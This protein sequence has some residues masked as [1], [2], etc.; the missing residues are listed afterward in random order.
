M[1]TGPSASKKDTSRCQSVTYFAANPSFR[2]IQSKIQMLSNFLQEQAALYA[3]GAMTE[4]ER[5]ELEVIL[6]F[7]PE[8]NQHV[9]ELAEIALALL[10][11]APDTKPPPP[12]LKSRISSL[13]STHPQESR[14]EGLV[15]CGPDGLVQWT[16]P[17]FSEMCG[18]SFDELRGK[19]LGPLLQGQDTDHETVA[20]LRQAIQLHQAC[21]E[22]IL[23][24][25]KNGTPYWVDLSIKPIQ[26]DTG[27]LL[28]FYARERELAAN[29]TPPA[30]SPA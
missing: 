11:Q 26:D 18:Y 27:A 4:A 29:T 2:F 13:I 1:I 24:Y 22:T 9:S 7:H 30:L 23:N 3:S 10:S 5:A 28:W 19:K 12:Q 14:S 8:M 21:R 6:Q 15:V 20:R 17:A 16:N 25:H